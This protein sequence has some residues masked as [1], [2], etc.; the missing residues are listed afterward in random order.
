M[1]LNIAKVN[2][3][4]T[5]PTN[6]TDWVR[7]PFYFGQVKYSIINKDMVYLLS[8]VNNKWV[9]YRS[10]YHSRMGRM[11]LNENRFHIGQIKQGV[12]IVIPDL[13]KRKRGEHT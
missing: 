9:K 4:K 10:L 11:T 5:L 12:I 1:L 2:W 6:G 13:A 8:G 7:F 3:G